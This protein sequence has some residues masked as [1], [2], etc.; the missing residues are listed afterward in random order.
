MKRLEQRVERIAPGK[1]D[2]FYM[3]VPRDQYEEAQA[4]LQDLEVAD[5]ESTDRLEA[6]EAQREPEKVREPFRKA[7]TEEPDEFSDRT[8]LKHLRDL[9]NSRV[10]S[11]QN[12]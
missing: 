1:R 2:V 11:G 3:H 4:I 8:R 6:A 10:G 12:W 5:S 9:S 7:Q